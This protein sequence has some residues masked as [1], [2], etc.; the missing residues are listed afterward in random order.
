MKP[1]TRTAGDSRVCHRWAQFGERDESGLPNEKASRAAPTRLDEV[2]QNANSACCCRRSRPT[3]NAR[4]GYAAKSVRCS[5]AIGSRQTAGPMGHGLT[6]MSQ[7][8]L[9]VPLPASGMETLQM[10]PTPGRAGRS[11]GSVEELEGKWR[12][13]REPHEIEHL[14]LASLQAAREQLSEWLRDHGFTVIPHKGR[15]GQKTG[16]GP[17]NSARSSPI[18]IEEIFEQTCAQPL[19]PSWAAPTAGGPA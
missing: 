15:R 8:G 5:R 9:G 16:H 17:S 10:L 18:D 13:S 3:A 4:G 19:P 6:S 12:H 1:Q 14:A 7:P 11:N 2:E